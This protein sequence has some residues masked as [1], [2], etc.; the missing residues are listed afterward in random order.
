MRR[1]SA[2]MLAAGAALTAMAKP[3][4]KKF[5]NVGGKKPPGYTHVVSSPPGTMIFIS[6]QGGAGEDGKMPA[7]FATQC[8]NTFK[9]L[10]KCLALAGARF[11]DVVKINYFVTDMANT[12]ELRKIRAKYLNMD[13]PPAA[14]L[15]QSGLGAGLLVEIEA[16]AMI[17]R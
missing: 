2:L 14:T 10:G 12:A 7:D 9:N 13:A 4:A 11:E 5:L 8:D 1:L 17:A 16:I 15:V 6:G 3:L